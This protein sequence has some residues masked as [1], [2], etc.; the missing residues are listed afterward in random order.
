VDPG[1]WN[2]IWLKDED[3]KRVFSVPY[4]EC[5]YYLTNFRSHAPQDASDE[6]IYEV[7]VQGITVM[8]VYKMHPPNIDMNPT[9]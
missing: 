4:K 3:R 7:K 5:E 8:A 9:P 6:K 2:L 1:E